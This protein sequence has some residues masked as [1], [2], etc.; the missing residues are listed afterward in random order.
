MNRKILTIVGAVALLAWTL[1]GVAAWTLTKEGV[2]LTVQEGNARTEADDGVALLE[3]RVAAVEGDLKALA[4]ALGTNFERLQ[5]NASQE[6]ADRAREVEEHVEAHVDA[7]VEEQV[8]SHFDRLEAALD[9][10][11]EERGEEARAAGAHVD[12]TTARLLAAVRDLETARV[13]AERLAAASPAAPSAPPA[14]PRSHLPAPVHTPVLASDHRPVKATA[15][16]TAVPPH[17]PAS[18]PAVATVAK[19]APPPTRSP[20]RPA[21]AA[22]PVPASAKAAPPSTGHGFLS[23]TLPSQSV[24]FDRRQ[25]WALVPSLSR[26]GFDGKSTLHGFTGVT[27]NLSGTVE[28]DLSRP[29]LDPK[30]EI[31]VQSATLDTG[32]A[33]RDVE[34]RSTLATAQHPEIMFRLVSFTPQKVDAHAERV[35]GI[36]HGQMSIKGTT[37]AVDMP[38]TLSLDE[39]RRLHVDGEMPLDMT[40][41]GIKPPSKLGVINVDR[42]VQVWIRLRAR[43]QEGP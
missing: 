37:R 36:T 1:G 22:T 4:K 17:A 12:E 29:N 25:R 26:V 5:Q 32:D 16:P 19:A 14:P 13:A 27:S 6:R 8:A 23:F 42:M 9:K 39:S 28:V 38:T 2:Q 7:H 40:A 24:A 43:I 18:R 10:D 30:A 11:R 31:H 33:A 3:D 41:Y 20:V 21:K 15:A 35:I 34:M